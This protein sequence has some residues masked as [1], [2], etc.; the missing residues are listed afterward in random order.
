MSRRVLIPV[1]LLVDC[2]P[3]PET[4]G[5]S[6]GRA[7]AREGGGADFGET[8]PGPDLGRGL[9]LAGGLLGPSPLA[10][11]R[12]LRALPLQAVLRAVLRARAAE[13]VGSN[14]EAVGG[15]VGP[16]PERRAGGRTG[17]R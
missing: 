6:E 7:S 12:C 17:V 16:V 15:S 1:V 9:D 3:G 13:V 11:V 5:D 4:S 2:G 14:S 8:G 10:P